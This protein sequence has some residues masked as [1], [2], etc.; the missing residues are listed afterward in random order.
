[1]DD[2]QAHFEEGKG[3]FGDRVNVT[4]CVVWIGSEV[5]MSD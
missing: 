1:M 5:F 3:V 4:V 2:V